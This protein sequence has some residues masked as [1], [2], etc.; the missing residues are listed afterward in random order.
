MRRGR[1]CFIVVCVL[2]VLTGSA[3]GATLRIGSW[4]RQDDPLTI[5]SEAI[6]VQA[7]AQANQ[8]VE[9]VSL[10][11]RRAMS[12]MLNGEIDGNLYRNATIALAHPEL[13]R[14]ET[15]I[16]AAAVRVYTRSRT[17][18]PINWQQLSGLRVAYRRGVIIIESHLGADVV[19][20][21]AKSEGDALRMAA[22][23]AVDVALAVE[24]AQGTENPVADGANLRRLDA[25]L[26]SHLVHHYLLK[27]HAAFALRLDAILKRMQ[28]SG[29][30]DMLRQ[31]AVMQMENPP[32]QR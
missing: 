12:M 6:L 10:P 1:F 3:H 7:Y 22:A 29:Q 24:P 32:R 13:V 23:G 4:D 15:P 25:A 11:I 21:E 28:Q 31:R 18:N 26:S 8:P 20:V 19:R 30:M 17:L 16:N 2:L 14:L 5:G 27:R 9:F